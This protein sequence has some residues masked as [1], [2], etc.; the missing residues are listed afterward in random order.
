LPVNFYKVW[1]PLYKLISINKLPREIKILE[2]G[3]GPGTATWGLISFYEY[4][5]L[6]NP[7]ID[8]RVEYDCV[9]IEPNFGEIFFRLRTKCLENLTGNLEVNFKKVLYGIDAFDYLGSLKKEEYDIILESNLVNCFENSEADNEKIIDSY[10]NAVNNG[11]KP[12]G[13]VIFIEPGTNEK[14]YELEEL[15]D[16]LINKAN[17]IKFVKPLKSNVNINQLSILQDLI[18]VGLRTC[19]KDKHWFSCMLMQKK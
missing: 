11:L 1:L 12:K 2:I 14:V 5:A 10:V 7:I 8:F 15:S 17:C 19:A 6:E 18:K 3:N 9:E 4:L 16:V 13:H